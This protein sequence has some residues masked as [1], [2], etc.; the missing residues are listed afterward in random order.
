[1]P[2]MI[3]TIDLCK[4]HGKLEVLRGIS[5]A[6]A[7]GE[8]AV[9]IGPSG[10]GKSTFLRCLNGLESFQSGS[11]TIDGL[12]LDATSPPKSRVT[13]LRQIRRNLGMVF[14]S[15]NLFP[16]LCVLKNVTLAPIQ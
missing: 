11:I 3:E 12:R 14:Q 9:I 2:P 13:P 6:V 8:V 10:G 4:R 1:M 15:F 5:L 7:E 16:H